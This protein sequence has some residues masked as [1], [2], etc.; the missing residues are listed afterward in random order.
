MEKDII[1][2][3]KEDIITNTK[4]DNNLKINI[5]STKSSDTEEIETKI[6]YQKYTILNYFLYCMCFY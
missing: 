6:K 1:T 4:E 5:S 2:N 3:T